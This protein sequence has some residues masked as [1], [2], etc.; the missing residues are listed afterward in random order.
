EPPYPRRIAARSAVDRLPARERATLRRRRIG[1]RLAPDA[2]AGSN[3]CRSERAT[4]RMARILFVQPTIMPPGGGHVLAAWMLQALVDRQR[5]TLLGWQAPQLDVVDR[6]AGTALAR[7]SSSV[8]TVP[9][10]VARLFRLSPIP[11]PFYRQLHLMRVARRA[12]ATF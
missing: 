5:V 10:I 3:G 4:I 9:P 2:P 12:V 6:H 1:R 8:A 11:L 7:A